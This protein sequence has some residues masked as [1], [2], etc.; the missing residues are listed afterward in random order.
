[1]CLAS[2]P[3]EVFSLGC[4][5]PYMLFEYRPRPGWADRIPA[6]PH[7][8]GTARLQTMHPSASSPTYPAGTRYVS[9]FAAGAMPRAAAPH[10]LAQSLL[11]LISQPPRPQR[12]SHHACRH[13]DPLTT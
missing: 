11:F 7:L 13:S 3:A 8:D 2:R 9:R 4:D 6:V 5:D 12:L 1:M 10:D